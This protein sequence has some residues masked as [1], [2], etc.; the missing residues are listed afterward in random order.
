MKTSKLIKKLEARGYEPREYSGR[1]MF[2]ESCVAI[3]IEDPCYV[4]D[5]ISCGFP[6][7]WRIDNLGRS[8]IL[9][10]TEHVWTEELEE[11]K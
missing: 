2:G 7:K 6:T 5:L 3:E 4:D 11:L 8:H 1:Y 10:W 9:Y